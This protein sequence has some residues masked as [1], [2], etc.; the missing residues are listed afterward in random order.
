MSG[1]QPKAAV[2][3]KGVCIV[4]EINP[5]ATY[6]RHQQGWV[7]EVYKNI[8]DLLERALVARNKKES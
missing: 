6:K 5:K 8:D 2:I 7:D 1:A 3:A 4:A